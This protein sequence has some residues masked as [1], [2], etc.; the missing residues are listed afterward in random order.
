[1]FIL[2]GFSIN[3][4]KQYDMAEEY[5]DPRIRDVLSDIEHNFAFTRKG[6]ELWIQALPIIMNFIIEGT[7]LDELLTR[8]YGQGQPVKILTTFD[9]FWILGYAHL[10]HEDVNTGLQ[11]LLEATKRDFA[12]RIKWYG[13]TI[14]RNKQYGETIDRNKRESPK[15]VPLDLGVDD[16]HYQTDSNGGKYLTDECDDLGMKLYSYAPRGNTI[17]FRGERFVLRNTISMEWAYSVV[18]QRQFLT[19]NVKNRCPSGID[20]RMPYLQKKVYNDVL[21]KMKAKLA[22]GKRGG[23]D[24]RTRRYY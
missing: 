1:M 11:P 19:Q 13:E 21:T 18:Y 5:D 7:A 12:D 16:R 8:E 17:I 15:T 2:V 24:R 14:K 6:Y 10:N 4:T 3:P 23:G 9:L 22:E 20:L